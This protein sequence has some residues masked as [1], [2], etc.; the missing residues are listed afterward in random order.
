M[1]LFVRV[2]KEAET[3]GTFKYRKV[4]LVKEGFNPDNM[5]DPVWFIDPAKGTYVPVTHDRYES[6]LAGT[7][8]F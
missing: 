5:A 7:Y 6:I 2:Q 8:R 4:D 3:T 1:P